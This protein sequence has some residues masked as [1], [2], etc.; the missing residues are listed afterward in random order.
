MYLLHLSDIHFRAREFGNAQDPFASIREN[1]VGDIEAEFSRLD[2]APER[3]LI[4][5]DIAYSGSCDEYEFASNWLDELCDRLGLPHD[6]VFVIPGNHDVDQNISET[7]SVK[8]VR[9]FVKKKAAGTRQQTILTV[10]NEEKSRE[11]LYSPIVAYNAFA[12]RYSCILEPPNE[13][14]AREYLELCNGWRLRLLGLNSALVSGK[15]DAK[16]SLLVDNASHGITP[17]SGVV[18]LVMCH[19]PYGWLEDGDELADALNNVAPLQLFGHEHTI[20]PEMGEDFVRLRSAAVNPE[21]NQEEWRPGYNILRLAVEEVEEAWQLRVN[22]CV[23][24]WQRTPPQ[25]VPLFSSRQQPYFE[26]TISLDNPPTVE[27]Q[28]T[29]MSQSPR[30]MDRSLA[31]ITDQITTM[32]HDVTDPIPSMRALTLRFFDLSYPKQSA[33]VAELGLNDE[34]DANRAASVR[35]SNALRKVRDRGMQDSLLHAIIRQ[36]AE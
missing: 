14:L 29:A 33:I 8:S 24:V 35:F 11:T 7:V 25:F 2:A 28:K 22:V 36:E 18:T 1:L 15:G 20:R 3:V 17:E 6:S 4:S 32:G 5:G 21:I 13:T 12:A 30:P 26:S 10:L 9:D 34:N 31:V 19:H 16:G 23:R 27:M